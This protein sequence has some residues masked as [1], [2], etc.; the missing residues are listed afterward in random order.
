MTIVK[1]TLAAILLFVG[2]TISSAD[3]GMGSRESF[4]DMR[5]GQRYRIVRIGNLT[6]MAENL[7]YKTG[8]SWCFKNDLVD[9]SNCRK[10]GRLYDWNTAMTACP[11]GWRL[12]NR[13][14]WDNLC[15]AVG[16]EKTTC[17]QYWDAWFGAATKLKSKSG[18]VNLECGTEI[19]GTDDYGFS[20]LPGGLYD[21][22]NA[23]GYHFQDASE[24]G[25]WWTATENGDSAYIRLMPYSYPSVYE[26]TSNKSYGFSVR[27][28]RN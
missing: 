14:N 26:S 28:V 24:I 19:G 20:A 10:Y 3:T 12:P 1:I 6:W 22:D 9:D 25:Y 27:C 13:E 8:S 7:N 4:I 21:P 15:Q 23:Y 16:G 11:A 18:W 17:N 2:Y 5:D